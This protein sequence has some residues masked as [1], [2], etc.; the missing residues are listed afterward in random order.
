MND[1]AW[2]TQGTLTLPY[3]TLATL[4]AGQSEVHLKR[5]ILSGEQRVFKRVSLLGREDTLAFNEVVLL[6]GIDHPNVARVFD[7]VEIAGSD[8]ALRLVEI[9]MPYYPSGSVLDA[10]HRGVRYSA[11][12][13]RDIA[14]HALRGLGCLH[15]R[16]RILHRDPK[17]ANLFLAGEGSLVKVGDFGEAVRMDDAGG[18][19][20]LISPQCWTPPESFT[21]GRYGVASDLYGMG[22]ALAELL[23]G[24]FPYDNYDRERL[25]I[26]LAGG[27]CGVRPR[28]MAFAAHVPDALRRIVRK[29]TRPEP[30]DRYQSADAMVRDLLAASFVDWGWPVF[31][32]VDM[33]W[34][35]SSMGKTFRVTARPIRGKGWRARAQ[36]LYAGGWQRFQGSTDVDAPEP[37]AAAAAAF[38]QIDMHLSRV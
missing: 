20:P 15:D 23:S 24:P 11:G 7:V 5:N 18:C 6:Q 33:V 2:V 19:D 4:H 28:D 16:H 13:A 34:T 38:S 25:A 29:A 3:G 9:M 32:E 31:R 27:K 26:R 35:G 17:P 30:H 22:M 21:G 8:P 1:G 14:V 37:L 12:E 10:M 36:R